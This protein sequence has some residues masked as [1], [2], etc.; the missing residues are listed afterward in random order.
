MPR[1]MA[2][3]DDTFA[4]DKLDHVVINLTRA[5]VSLLATFYQAMT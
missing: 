2:I 5:L 3:N 4:L 1:G